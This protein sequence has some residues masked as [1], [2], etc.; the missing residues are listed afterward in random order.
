MSWVRIDDRFDDHPK[1]VD[2]SNDAT[3][4][5]LRVL[6]YC[7]RHETDGRVKRRVALM[8]T[9]VDDPER[10]VAEL[11]EAGLWLDLGG[12]VEVHD[13]LSFQP[14]RAQ[15]AHARAEAAARQAASRARRQGGGQPPDV[16]PPSPAPLSRRESQRDS[17]VTHAVSNSVS[18]G[19]PSHPIPSISDPPF[20][21][22]RET[23]PAPD[24]P[25]VDE[26]VEPPHQPTPSGSVGHPLD[27]VSTAVL[28]ALEARAELRGVATEALAQRLASHC[29]EHG[30]PG[31]WSLEQVL[32]CVEQA[33]VKLGDEQA[34]TGVAPSQ[35]TVG[36]LVAAF[37]RSGPKPPARAS[38][39]RGGSP[40]R[41]QGAVQDYPVT[42]LD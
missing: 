29:R 8:A 15:A 26:L 10:V 6:A 31:R 36:R 40:L 22:A 38:P 3:A 12:I 37:V 39:G 23:D 34:S 32:E 35:G 30:H 7:G 19:D 16:T 4:A 24:G 17:G 9:R 20:A 2:L 14:S 25:E 5:W 18:P 11:V 42:V 41:Q 21:G 28:A 27:P 13:Y 33:A 1:F